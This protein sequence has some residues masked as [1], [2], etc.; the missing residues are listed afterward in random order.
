MDPT[1]QNGYSSKF[2]NTCDGKNIRIISQISRI[3]S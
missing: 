2:N 3:L 1:D